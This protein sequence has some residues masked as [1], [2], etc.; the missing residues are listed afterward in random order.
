MENPEL[1]FLM[2]MGLTR[3]AVS[4][5]NPTLPVLKELASEFLN[6]KVIKKLEHACLDLF[7]ASDFV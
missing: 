5:S 1:T 7:P 3:D 6:N 2:Q 4:C